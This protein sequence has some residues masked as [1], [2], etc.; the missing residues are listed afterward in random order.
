MGRPA[1]RADLWMACGK[2]NGRWFAAE[3][4]V[5]SITGSGSARHPIVAILVAATSLWAVP[6]A[7]HHSVGSPELCCAICMAAVCASVAICPSMT[8]AAAM[9]GRSLRSLQCIGN[10]VPA[11]LVAIATDRIRNF[12]RSRAVP[13]TLL[14]LAGCRQK[15]SLPN[16]CRHAVWF[17]VHRCHPNALKR[18]LAAH[19][20]VWFAK[21][22]HRSLTYSQERVLVGF[23][24]LPTSLSFL[25]TVHNM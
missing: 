2:P 16:V 23:M 5:K 8:A 14:R 11:K 7:A 18:R 6:C 13:S 17:P 15:W 20:N 19:N 9:V 10:Q 21:P 4:A 1:S 25:V 22:S 24:T 12:P 3:A